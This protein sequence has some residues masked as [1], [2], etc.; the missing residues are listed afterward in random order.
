MRPSVVV[1][2]SARPD[3]KYTPEMREIDLV[4]AA[5]EAVGRE[6]ARAGCD[7]VV[8]SSSDDYIEKDVVHGYLARFSVRTGDPSW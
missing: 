2:G 6:L 3:R 7:L 1:V 8:F 4:P 5:C